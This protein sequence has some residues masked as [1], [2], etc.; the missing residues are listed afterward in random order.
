MTIFFL[1]VLSS[2]V[3]GQDERFFQNVFKGKFAEERNNKNIFK[4]RVSTPRYELD[5]NRDGIKEALQIEKRDGM[6]AVLL[7]DSYGKKL[8]ETTLVPKGKRSH[9]FRASQVKISKDVEV[10]LLHY[11]EGDLESKTFEGSARLYFLTIRNKDLRNITL[12]KGPFFWSERERAAEKYWARRYTVN[13]VDYNNDG[14][15]EISVLFNNIARVYY[16]AP[17]GNWYTL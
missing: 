14:Y 2:S 7:Y 15:K 12:T 4:I 9:L 8:Y 6:D 1:L 11:Y 5:L 3:Y 10:L 17:E 13:T 16:F